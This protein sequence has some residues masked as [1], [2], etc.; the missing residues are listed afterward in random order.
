MYSLRLFI[1]HGFMF[2][3]CRLRWLLPSNEQ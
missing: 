3:Y 1:S 2:G